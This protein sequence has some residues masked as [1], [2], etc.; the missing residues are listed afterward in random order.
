MITVIFAHHAQRK[1]HDAHLNMSKEIKKGYALV[2][3]ADGTSA[4]LYYNDEIVAKF[5]LA[6]QH[7][8]LVPSR[9]P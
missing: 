5:N 1:L 4:L 3:T 6:D 8:K 2:T 7:V 9:T